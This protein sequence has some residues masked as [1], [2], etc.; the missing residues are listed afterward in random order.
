M[1]SI[2][3]D[4]RVY[5]NYSN[6]YL[7][8]RDLASNLKDERKYRAGVLTDCDV[9]QGL[10]EFMEAAESLKLDTLTGIEITS[11]YGDVV[12]RIIGYG[13]NLKKR[14]HLEDFIHSHWRMHDSRAGLVLKK[15]AKIGLM[16][17]TS[18][19]VMEGTKSP[20]SYLSL[21]RI[22]EHR[23]LKDG[24][25]Y[26]DSEKEL[27]VGGFAHVG[28]N[29][30]L[31]M[32]PVEA[33]KLIEEI[34]GKAVLACPGD[35]LKVA[36]DT[37][38]GLDIFHRIIEELKQKNLFGLE[39]YSSGHTYEENEMFADVA[40]ENNLFITAGSGYQKELFSKL[41]LTH[42]ISYKSFLEFKEACSL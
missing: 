42:S 36:G 15:Y 2:E 28:V 14:Y 27:E 41:L 1:M 12:I 29:D 17:A 21:S 19:E 6:G 35:I 5:S 24:V 16:S 38:E 3:V 11:V 22:R 30:K 18:N 31:I 4:M 13:F 10:P 33:I 32:S 20:G 34:G 26:E 37:K 40:R 25:S 23:F 8:P 7:S 39:A 9:F